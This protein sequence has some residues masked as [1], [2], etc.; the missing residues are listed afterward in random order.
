MRD[1]SSWY[2]KLA[3]ELRKAW[4]TGTGRRRPGRL[5][6]VELVLFLLERAA[7]EEP[8]RAGWAFLGGYPFALVNEDTPERRRML[9]IARHHLWALRRPRMWERALNQYNSFPEE[10]RGYRVDDLSLPPVRV[11]S[12]VAEA[13]WDTY[14]EVLDTEPPFH[15]RDELHIAEPGRS[16]RFVQGKLHTSV[17]LPDYLPV[18]P[19]GRHR[20]VRPG[21]KDHI[22]VSRDQLIETARWMDDCLKIKDPWKSWARRVRRLEFD[23]LDPESRSFVEGKSLSV[24]GLLHLV[25][26][27]GAGKST[28]RDVLS[29]HLAR[30][31]KKVTIVVGDVAEQLSIVKLFRGLDDIKAAPVLGA[32]TRVRNTQRMHRRLASSG[33]GTLLTHNP[34]AFAYL[35]TACP[36]DALRSA[37]ALVPLHPSEAPCTTL[38]PFA[39]HPDESKSAADDA[40]DSPAQPEQAHGCPLWGGC[41]RHHGARELVDAQIWV[42]NPASLIYGLAPRHQNRERARFLEIAALRSDLIIVDEADRVQMQ[43]DTMFVP[44]ATLVGMAPDSWLDNLQT[45]TSEE[46][47]RRGRLQL[48]D[49]DVARWSS[50][51]S[52]VIV[53]TNR[54]YSML[55]RHEKLST[56][57]QADYFSTW[58]IQQKLVDDW[59]RDRNEEAVDQEEEADAESEEDTDPEDDPEDEN[60][61]DLVIGSREDDRSSRHDAV[62]ALLDSFRDDPL[63]DR[64]SD[65][66]ELVELVRLTQDLLHTLDEEEAHHRARKM[67]S[68]L[69]WRESDGEDELAVRTLRLEFMLLLAVLQHRLDVLTDLW[70]LVESRLNLEA[71]DNQLSR[72]PPVDYGPLVPE[73]PMGNVLGFQFLTEEHSGGAVVEARSPVLRFFR[74]AGVGRSLLLDLHTMTGPGEAQPPHVLLMS[75]TSWAGK[76]A[77]A[78]VIAPVGTIL[79]APPKERLGIR[80]TIFH[81]LFLMGPDGKPLHLSGTRPDR[82]TKVLELI[83]DRLG[84]PRDGNVFSDLETELEAI[85]NPDRERILLL[86]GS[87]E[88]ARVG[89]EFLNGI[90]RWRGKVCQ[91][92]ADDVEL[93]VSYGGASPDW[94]STPADHE[95]MV[96]RRG[97]VAAFAETGAQIL[98]A[99]LLSVERGHNILNNVGQAAIG[100][101]FFLAR[102]HPRPHDINLAVQGINSWVTRYARG[103]DFATAVAEAD[104][105]DV[106]GRAFRSEAR[107]R[108][109]RLL[110]RRMAWH[111]LSDDDKEAF[112]WDRIVVMWQVIGRLVRGGVPARVVFVDSRFAPREASGRGPDTYRSGLLASMLHVLKPYMTDEEGIAL[113]DRQL[114][115]ALYEPLYDAL[116]SIQPYRPNTGKRAA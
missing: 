13:R 31:G 101:V 22:S 72:R 62:V 82:R 6:A 108:W 42:A 90:P 112:T 83:L 24:D 103:K 100:S 34:D 85:H 91:L 20:L 95:P 54:I 43:L 16:Y 29:V 61:R 35:S 86:V 57:V 70:P 96:L 53:A 60:G 111:F 9:R 75:G 89:A 27:V 80:R 30:Q 55:M 36:L 47:A 98:F 64:R 87:Y 17:S 74:C 102:P 84:H 32:S 25:G 12:P 104:D 116:T 71:T 99:P 49:V 1:R 15:V 10:L 38:V 4:P 67:L 107:A 56:W 66:P 14:A 50:S 114:V 7:P 26:M 65:D 28:L 3:K 115:R 81:T 73:S 76:A 109:R 11:G 94:P 37:E 93:E 46:L 52:L 92:I 19:G 44:S 48:S 77:G 51:L 2:K 79:K 33:S 23:V 88:E 106:A 40:E 41:P 39:S 5:C 8:A 45:H 78:H 68:A 59:F 69:A 97:D 105:L 113:R 21:R 110:T 63:G 18:L 58:T